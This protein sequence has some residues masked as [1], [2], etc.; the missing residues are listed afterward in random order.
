MPEQLL[1][2]IQILYDDDDYNE[3]YDA[4][5]STT[6]ITATLQ[7]TAT[8]SAE[9]IFVSAIQTIQTLT[10]SSEFKRPLNAVYTVYS[11]RASERALKLRGRDAL[12]PFNL[13]RR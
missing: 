10:D 2:D 9:Q 5:Y 4:Q 12:C 1:I 6:G 8:D 11:Y 13:S 7:S 3:L